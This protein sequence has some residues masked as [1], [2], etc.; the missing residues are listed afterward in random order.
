MQ[1]SVVKTQGDRTKKTI[2]AQ[3][4]KSLQKRS[5]LFEITEEVDYIHNY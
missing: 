1:M 3:I 2:A 5:K 4:G